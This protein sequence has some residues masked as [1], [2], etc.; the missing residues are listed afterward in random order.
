MDTIGPVT[1]LADDSDM[2]P[3]KLLL[4]WVVDENDRTV[5]HRPSKLVFLIDYPPPAKGEWVRPSSLSAR[6]VHV[7]DGGELPAPETLRLIG[8]DAIHAFVLSA[9]ACH[10]PIAGDDIPF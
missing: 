9:D 5:F 3:I 2:R 7:C 1:R 8:K 6:V 10:E 4:D